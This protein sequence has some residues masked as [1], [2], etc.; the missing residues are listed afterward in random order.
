[1]AYVLR[2]ETFVDPFG[3]LHSVRPTK[4]RGGFNNGQVEAVSLEP[5]AALDCPLL[6]SVPG[7]CP[8]VRPTPLRGRGPR[9][10]GGRDT[11][12]GDAGPWPDPGSHAGHAD[13]LSR[14]AG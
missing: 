11:G 12:H 5:A 14:P 2:Y 7:R 13:G 9:G 10:R 1:M 4:K 3:Y 8:C 6:S